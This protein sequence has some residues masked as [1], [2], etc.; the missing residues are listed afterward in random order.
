MMNVEPSFSSTNI[1]SIHTC[2]TAIY[3]F[4]EIVMTVYEIVYRESR[5]GRIFAE[6]VQP[7]VHTSNSHLLAYLA[8]L[9]L[10]S[11]EPQAKMEG[12]RDPSTSIC[13]Q[14]KSSVR[15]DLSRNPRN[16][17]SKNAHCDGDEVT[18]SFYFFHHAHHAELEPKNNV[19]LDKV[20]QEMNDKNANCDGDVATLSFIF[21]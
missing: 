9:S 13:I 4:H 7:S 12:S 19:I 14:P 17:M 15:N 8:A 1:K 20:S 3:V 6:V 18:P 16:M 21:N 2:P 5:E 10:L 11:S